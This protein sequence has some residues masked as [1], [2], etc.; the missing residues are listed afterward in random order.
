MQIALVVEFEIKVGKRAEFDRLITEHART[1]LATEPGCRRF[2]VLQAI[3]ESGAVD[4]DRI[5]LYELYD[6]EAALAAHQTPRLAQVR[7]AMA[8][9]VANRR[10][11]KCQMR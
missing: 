9:L 10:L 1:T 4:A 11:T 6:D 3:T 2:D 5:L 8:P 7:E